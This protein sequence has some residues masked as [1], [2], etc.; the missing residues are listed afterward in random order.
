MISEERY[1][2][3]TKK[4]SAIENE[5]NRLKNLILKPNAEV[6]GLIKSV[7]GSELKD[8]IR[9][10]DLLKRPEMNYNILNNLAKVK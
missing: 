3:F 10:S 4:K 7:G 5:I 9:A 1:E 8:G 2:R 6:Q